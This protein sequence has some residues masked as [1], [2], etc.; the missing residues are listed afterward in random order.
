MSATTLRLALVLVL[1]GVGTTALTG[2]KTALIPAV[3]GA[4]FAV[5]GKLAEDESKRMHAMHFAALLALVG[6]LA[7]LGMG[8]KGALAGFAKPLA[9]LEQLLLGILCANYLR[10]CIESFKA[11]RRRQ[12]EA[13]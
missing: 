7:G 2:A 12:A 1:L 4:L 10:Q 9:V 11:A 6:A 13:A 5:L 8:I 3:F